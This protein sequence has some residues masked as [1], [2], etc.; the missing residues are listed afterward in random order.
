MDVSTFNVS[1]VD[2]TLNIYMQYLANVSGK[3]RFWK[4]DI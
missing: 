3:H 2:F 1:C 4:Y